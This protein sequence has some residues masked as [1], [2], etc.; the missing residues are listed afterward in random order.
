[1]FF[2]CFWIR[3]KIKKIQLQS[4]HR[5]VFFFLEVIRGISNFF[6]Y[7]R[8]KVNKKISPNTHYGDSLVGSAVEWS[9]CFVWLD[10]LVRGGDEK[11]GRHK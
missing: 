8:E 2:G 5:M 6:G 4:I 10:S 7:P 11:L 9:W 3:R 1:M